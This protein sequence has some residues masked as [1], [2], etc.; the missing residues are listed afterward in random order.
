MTNTVFQRFS[1]GASRTAMAVLLGA[2][3]ACSPGKGS[4]GAATATTGESRAQ[5]TSAEAVHQLYL[6]TC[7]SCHGSGVGGAPRVG[8]A[9]A[10]E[11]RLEKGMDTLIA[12]AT[13]GYQA[14]PPRGL[15]FDCS[16]AEFA[17]LIRYMTNT[18][19]E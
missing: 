8:D 16:E 11:P 14:M 15:C 7:Q 13:G 3:A 12:N 19:Q 5:R 9:A 2:C 4:D 10:W 1:R 6:R 18:E 17:A